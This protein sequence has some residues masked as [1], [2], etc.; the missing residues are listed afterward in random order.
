GTAAWLQ[1]GT[2]DV[3][4]LALRG[5]SVQAPAMV[6]PGQADGVV[7][8]AL[9][10]GRDGAEAVARGVGFNAGQ[11]R[12]GDSPWSASGLRAE[13]VPFTQ[14]RLATTQ[15]HWAMEGRPIALERP[16]AEYQAHPEEATEALRGPQPT[17]QKPVEYP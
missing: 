9:G 2:G 11:L 16:V 10:Y 17:L 1:V 15:Q 3:L 13:R 6:V 14:Q 8:V 4:R 12:F 5:R 7:G